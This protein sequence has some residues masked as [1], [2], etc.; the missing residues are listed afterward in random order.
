VLLRQ[1]VYTS[2]IQGV[3]GWEPTEMTT[4]M[5]PLFDAILKLPKPQV[6]TG[7]NAALQLLVANVDYDSFKG[8]LGIG[9]IRS[10]VV[11]KVRR[12]VTCCPASARRA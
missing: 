5:V 9:R 4:N 1:V 8:K 3:A 10:G 7:A 11:K 6:R 2:A 12:H